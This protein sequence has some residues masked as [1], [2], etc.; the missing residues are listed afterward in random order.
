MATI[1]NRSRFTVG[2]KNRPDLARHFPFNKLAQATAY[3]DELRAAGLKPRLD[4]LDEHWF[5]RIR[6]NG[7]RP[8]QTTFATREEA[9]A[10]VMKVEEERSRGLFIDYTKAHNTSL[11]ELLVR[12]L[13]TEVPRKKSADLERYKIEGWLE[14]SGAQ[15]VRLLQAHRERLRAKG[16]RIRSAAFKMRKPSTELAWIHKRLAEVTTTD[17]EDFI[18]ERLELVEPGTVDREIDILKSVF[19]VVLTVWDYPLA[20]NPMDAVRRPRYF[21]ERDRRLTGDEEHRLLDALA[22]LDRERAIEERLAEL[23]NAALSAQSFSSASARKKVL[24]AVRQQLLPIAQQSC[25]IVPYLE[26]FYHFQVMTAARRGET[27]GLTWERIDFEAGTA[28][29]PETKNGRSR[30]LSLRADLLQRLSELPREDE[31]VFPVGVD[32]LVGAWNRACENA[33]IKDLRIHDLRHEAI[34]RVAETGRFSLPELQQFS[35]HRDIRM[36]MRYSHLCASRLARKLDEAF[37]NDGAIRQHRGRR[38]LNK[39]ASVKVADVLGA[40]E[41]SLPSQ[42]WTTAAASAEEVPDIGVPSNVIEFP[43]RQQA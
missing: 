14:D 42:A 37:N 26:T 29:L 11:A 4:Q 39:V 22:Q 36:L 1:E 24:A 34:S 38:L 8:L 9:N 2:V 18:N 16:E 19:K 20:K 6:Q 5:V 33:A 25:R 27:L 32:M 3:R 40:E 41:E 13:E 15:G 30:K 28:F 7:Y 35:G 10:F 17:V 31:H 23:A 12:Y 43:R 21:N